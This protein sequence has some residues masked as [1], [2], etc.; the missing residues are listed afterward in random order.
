MLMVTCAF[1]FG[2]MAKVASKV[3]VPTR[4]ALRIANL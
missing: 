1:T 4:S 2:T 3:V